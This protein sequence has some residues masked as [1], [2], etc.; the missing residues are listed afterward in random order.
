MRRDDKDSFLHLL[1]VTPSLAELKDRQGRSLLHQAA[2]FQDPFYVESLLLHG[3]LPEQKDSQNHLPIHYAAMSGGL[4]VCKL[5]LQKNTV[6]ETTSGGATPL[7]VAIQNHQADA[8]HLFLRNKAKL[9]F[10]AGGYTTLHSAL[11]EGNFEIIASILQHRQIASFINV[12]SLEGGT[13]LMLSCEL[14]NKNLVDQLLAL[15]ADPSVSRHDGLTAIEIAV[16]RNCLPVLE[17]LLAQASPSALAL[18]A[19]FQKGSKALVEKLL[20]H[21]YTYKNASD[22]NA[23]HISL[24]YG[25]VPVALSIIEQCVNG[26]F[27]NGKNID[28][29]TPLKIAVILGVW[30]VVEALYNK[31]IA[32]DPK[33]LLAMNY[34]PLMKQIFTSARLPFSELQQAAQVAAQVGNFEALSYIFEPGGVDLSLLEGPKGWRVLHYLAKSDGLFLFRKYLSRTSDFR[35]SLEDD[36][37][38]TLAAIAVEYGSRR[39]LKVL[40]TAMK[41]ASDLKSSSTG[42]ADFTISFLEKSFQDKHLFYLAIESSMEDVLL[43]MVDP[44]SLV[45]CVLDGN[46]TLPAH[47]AARVGS[48]KTLQSLVLHGACLTRA[49]NNGWTPLDYAVRIEAAEA[50]AFLLERKVPVTATALFQAAKHAEET[51]LRLLI[52]YN[53]SSNALDDAMMQAIHANESLAFSRLIACNASLLYISDEG[54]TPTLLASMTGQ[55]DIL[56]IILHREL[57]DE[58]PIFGKRPLHWAAERKYASCVLLLLQAG[59][60][61]SPDL[62]GFTAAQLGGPDLQEVFEQREDILGSIF[63]DALKEDDISRMR[64]LIDSFSINRSIVANIGDRKVQVHPL[65]LLIRLSNGIQANQLIDELLSRAEIDF[66]LRDEKGNTFVHNLFRQDKS[67][68]K[69]R[70][71]D[72]GATN[73][74][75]QTPV[76]IAALHASEQLFEDLLSYLDSSNLLHL[77]EARDSMGR[78]PIF[79]AIER[80]DESIV[81]QLLVKGA[82]LNISDHHLITPLAMACIKQASGIMKNLLAYG[83]APNQLVAIDRITPLYIA[84]SNRSHLMIWYLLS[85]GANPK[86]RNGDG[87]HPM[88]AAAGAGLDSIIR[89]FHSL[90]ISLGIKDCKGFEPKDTATMEGH[91]KTLEMLLSMRRKTIDEPLTICETKAGNSFEAFQGATLLHLACLA[92]HPETAAWLICR[93]ANPESKTKAGY[94][95][96]SFAAKSSASG[97][98]FPLLN[99]FTMLGNPEYLRAALMSA[100]QEDH[101]ESMRELYVRGVPINAELVQG[102]T[103]LHIACKAGAL[104]CTA[105]LLA[106]G[107]EPS[108][109][110]QSK[111]TALELAASNSS[112]EQF[113]LIV[114]HV[115]SDVN[116]FNLRGQTLMHIAASCGNLAHIMVLLKRQAALNIPNNQGRTPLHVAVCAG[117][118]EAVRLLLACGADLYIRDNMGKFPIDLVQASHSKTREIINLF[119]SVLEEEREHLPLLH[120]AVRTRSSLA[121]LLLVQMTDIDDIHVRDARGFSPLYIAVQAGQKEI[122]KTLLRGGAQVDEESL[123]HVCLSFPNPPIAR[124]L[125]GLGIEQQLRQDILGEVGRSDLPCKREIVEILHQR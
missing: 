106:N 17:S 83:A 30:E 97:A 52:S 56:Q 69:L 75:G 19:A 99:P 15:G 114:E 81:D 78:T 73:H 45:N 122:V 118:N 104:Q 58:R 16:Q 95:V 74:K 42:T 105:W 64:D 26:S 117:H 57:R 35:Q 46:G 85:H 111:E 119:R 1:E 2:S 4:R 125:A 89:L 107:A 8:V 31:G 86:I 123:R 38:K 120:L 88:H 21:V 32:V 79:Y 67:P 22:D 18:E 23:L 24:R 102:Y 47:I 93:G 37:H 9:T 77:I 92:N 87:E 98:L 82:D 14:D 39:V 62:S 5:L 71:I 10:L 54:L 94:S 100:I 61:D 68:L 91:T 12:N 113:R 28:E 115:D 41:K 43:E 66:N 44:A 116:H 55:E 124:L 51:A 63:M 20:A 76:H 80:L 103:G 109:Q 110:C 36:G 50:I 7:I 108:L 33:D 27:L 34:H 72:L 6:N 90:G 11:H 53:E 59:H 121:V 13:P 70:N 29:E 48:L 40:L 84:L 101:I 96:L 112:Y 3:L 49:D 60:A 65:H 25:N